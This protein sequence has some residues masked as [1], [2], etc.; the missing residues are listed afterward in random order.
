MSQLC[1]VFVTGA[2]IGSKQA[3]IWR[4]QVVDLE[5]ALEAIAQLGPM[6]GQALSMSDQ[7]TQLANLLWGHPDSRDQ[8]G[9]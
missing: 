8:V 5:Q 6:P 9:G 4:S 3:T 1:A 2:L 7:G